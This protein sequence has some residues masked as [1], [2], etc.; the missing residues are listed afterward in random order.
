MY[1]HTGLMRRNARFAVACA[2]SDSPRCSDLM[3]T[4][5]MHLRQPCTSIIYSGNTRMQKCLFPVRVCARS[6]TTTRSTQRM[7]TKMSSA[8]FYVL[9]GCSFHLQQS[10]FLPARKRV[11][12][13]ASSASPQL[14][15]PQAYRPVS[16][17]TRRN[18]KHTK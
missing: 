7:S 5:Q 4:T 8:R 2:V 10:R 15:F 16:V 14:R 9:T 6:S 11:S 3:T 1:G 17:T 18:T 12:A 13:M